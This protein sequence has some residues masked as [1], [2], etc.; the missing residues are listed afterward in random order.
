MAW[1]KV[2]A[3]SASKR[4]R[5]ARWFAALGHLIR[6]LYYR[7]GECRP[8]G[9]CKASWIAGVFN[10]DLRNVK[11]ARSG[12]VES[13]LLTV[14]RRSQVFCNR[15]G[16]LVTVNLS[17][18]GRVEDRRGLPPPARRVGGDLPPP[19]KERE[20]LR[21]SRNQEPRPLPTG[22]E[23][24]GKPAPSPDLRHV[25]AADLSC[26]DR[27]A[28]LHEQAQRAGYVNGSQAER[29]QFFAA[30]AHAAAVGRSNPPGL[31]ASLVRQRRWGLLTLRDE[32]HARR[33][34]RPVR[35]SPSALPKT[36]AGGQTQRAGEV[37]D[38]LL[39]SGISAGRPAGMLVVHPR[40]VAAMHR[41][42]G[43]AA[44][45]AQHVSHG[46]QAM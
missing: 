3:R 28:V 5:S 25:V 30:A 23:A 43:Q 12:L 39:R 8:T 10:V 35:R 4:C 16:L 38:A 22:S 42:V 21:I 26:P 17:W 33:M 36:D 7:Q 14:E 18:D 15:F 32:D 31:F 37:L 1:A 9:T 27:L 13:G 45:H 19:K 2:L 44:G 24:R 34:I 41:V 29:L 6:C 46:C 20:L 40:L 11:A